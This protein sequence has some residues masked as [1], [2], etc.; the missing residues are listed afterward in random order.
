MHRNV[1]I[2]EDFLPL[3]IKA[4]RNLS[5]AGRSNVL[6]QLAIA[7]GTKRNDGSDTLLEYFANFYTATSAAQVV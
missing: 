7:L 4:A 6:Y 2:P 5:D 3:C 1:V